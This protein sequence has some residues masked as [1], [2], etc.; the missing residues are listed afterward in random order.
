MSY[1]R[2]SLSYNL[3]GCL[4]RASVRVYYEKFHLIILYLW[5]FRK[6]ETVEITKKKPNFLFIKTASCVSKSQQN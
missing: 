5:Q 4:V 1:P 3:W 6:Q 2:V